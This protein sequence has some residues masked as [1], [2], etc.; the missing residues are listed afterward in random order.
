[1]GRCADISNDIASKKHSHIITFS[2]FH[3]L[4]S[5]HNKKALP[6]EGLLSFHAVVYFFI[7]RTANL[8]PSAST[9]RK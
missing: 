1:M 7:I 4:L 2:H 9:S 5:H 3:I 8:L 6:V